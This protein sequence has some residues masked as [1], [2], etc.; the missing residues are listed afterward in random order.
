MTDE[1]APAAPPV[2][3]TGV[4]WGVLAL[5]MLAGIGG[6]AWFAWGVYEW[7]TTGYWLVELPVAVAGAFVAG[8]MML[9]ITGILYRVDRLRG[10]PHREVA[11]FE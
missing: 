9:F 3:R 5:L 1:P 7:A 4:L 6:A 11:L 10:V 2:Y 8:L